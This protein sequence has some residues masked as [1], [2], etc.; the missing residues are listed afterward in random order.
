[1]TNDELINLAINELK[2]SD[3]PYKMFSDFSFMKGLEKNDPEFIKIRYMLVRLGPF[4]SHTDNAIKLSAL[5]LTIIS[6]FGDWHQYKKSLKPKFDFI[7]I[8]TFVI[9]LLTFIWL[10]VF[11]A[12]RNEKLKNEISI[13]KQNQ[14]SL[15]LRTNLLQDSLSKTNLKE[16]N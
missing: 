3:K 12:I 6:D 7:K 15:I 13:L 14:D 2:T 8:G 4:E 1:M 11:H 10:L 9:A 5:G 16:D